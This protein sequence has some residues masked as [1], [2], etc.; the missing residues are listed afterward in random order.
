MFLHKVLFLKRKGKEMSVLRKIG[1]L[2]IVVGMVLM[3]GPIVHADIVPL[4]RVPRCVKIDNIDQWFHYY[5]IGYVSFLSS[6]LT[7]NIIDHRRI[8]RRASPP[9][10]KQCLSP[11]SFYSPACPS[12][13]NN[14]A[15]LR[16]A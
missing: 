14:Y 8:A 15:T 13:I 7:L 5:L 6:Q 12:S 2:V 9:R 11:V 10:S 16:N 1:G 4:P 3:Y